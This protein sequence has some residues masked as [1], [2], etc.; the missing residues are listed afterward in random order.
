MV[1]RLAGQAA[2]CFLGAV[3]QLQ[4]G[5]KFVSFEHRAFDAKPGSR[6]A[7]IPQVTVA[8]K[9]CYGHWPLVRW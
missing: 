7:N 5:V 4:Q 1:N 2:A 9:R 3:E 6:G 8:A